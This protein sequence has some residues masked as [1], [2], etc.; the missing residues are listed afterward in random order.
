MKMIPYTP[1]GQTDTEPYRLA[2]PCPPGV[3]CCCFN[4][5]A[6]RPLENHGRG[7][8][9]GSQGSHKSGRRGHLKKRIN[10]AAVARTDWNGNPR[11]TAAAALPHSWYPGMR[12]R[13][14]TA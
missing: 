10:A 3:M 12:D 14:E 7:G 5:A 9:R 2:V 6:G 13:P 8:P 1:C 4:R 11:R